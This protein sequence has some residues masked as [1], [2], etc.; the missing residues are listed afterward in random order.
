MKIN[1]IIQV[2]EQLAPPSLQES[3]DN[4][5]LITGSA[6]W[7]CSG[8]ICTLDATEAVILEAKEKGCNLVVAHHPIVFSGLKK[9]NGKNYVEKA[10]ITAIKHDIAIYAIHTNLDNV[11]NGV[12]HIIADRLGLINRKILA[13]KAGLLIKLYTFVPI[14]EADKLREALFAAGAGDIGQYSHCSFNTD[15]KGSFRAGEGTNP[16]VGEIGKT[17]LEAETKV[18]V[19]FPAWKQQEVLHA[20][21][22]THPYEE[23]AYDLVSLAN[24]YQDVGSGLMGELPDAM[25][26]TFFFQMLKTSFE[27]KLVRHTPFLGKKIKKV[28]L[29]GGSGSFLTGKAQAAGADI[30]ISADFKY[31]EFFDANDRMV[32]AD[33]GHWE[34]EQYTTDLLID[35]L[36]AKFPTF[37]VLKSGIKTNPVNYFLG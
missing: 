24:D 29:C 17:H 9:L 30:Y 25:D 8:I 20:L 32:I 19:I 6:T 27:L 13:P 34:S 36:Q 14:A 3:Y 15:G 31:H 12:N 23:V 5:G 22:H 28:A 33:I 11:K 37:A 10:V 16:H 21:F 1:D 4:A 7:N 18:E 2:L 35:V 26:E